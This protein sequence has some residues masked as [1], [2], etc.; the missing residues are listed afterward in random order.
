MANGSQISTS[1]SIISS[2]LGF[3]ALSLS[4]MNTS[5]ATV[6]TAGSKVEIKS[7][8][9]NFSTDLTPNASSWT[10]IATA[11]TAYLTLLPSGTAGSQIVSA[12]WSVT[13]PVWSDS[14]QDRRFGISVVATRVGRRHTKISFFLIPQP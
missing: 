11:N 2:L 3:Q 12:S 1:V 13:A 8:F 14:A 10:A 5:A 6:I 4:N 9:F 7:A